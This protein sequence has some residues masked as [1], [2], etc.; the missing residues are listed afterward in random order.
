M[1]TNKWNGDNEENINNGSGARVHVQQYYPWYG[2]NN[3]IM[4]VNKCRLEQ[5]KQ[6]QYRCSRSSSAVYWYSTAEYIR[7]TTQTMRVPVEA[8]LPIVYYYLHLVHVVT[9]FTLSLLG[10]ERRKLTAKV[11]IAAKT[12]RLR[13]W[14][15]IGW[16]EIGVPSYNARESLGID[17]RNMILPVLLSPR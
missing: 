10:I 5:H 11:T 16:I 2:N 6:Q 13:A 9:Y 8:V 3:T 14:G 1:A 7:I 15:V 17:G 4:A 12:R